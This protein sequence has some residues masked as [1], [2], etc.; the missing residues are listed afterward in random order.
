MIFVIIIESKVA[1]ISLKKGCS[2]HFK[3]AERVNGVMVDKSKYWTRPCFKGYEKVVLGDSSV[4]GFARIRKELAGV[5]I[6]AYG[7]IEI[8]EMVCILQ[9]G[10][11][12]NDWDLT[13]THIRNRF[14]ANRDE[15]PTIRFCKHCYSECANEFKGE[16]IFVI[17]LNN[18]LKAEK[19]PFAMPNGQNMQNYT[20]MFEMLDQ[21]CNKMIPNAEIRFAPVLKVERLAE[22]NS[23]LIE[24]AATKIAEGIAARNMIEMDPLEP[25]QKKLFD[26]DGVHMRNREGTDFWMKVF[27]NKMKNQ[28]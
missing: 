20:G 9:A 24:L 17:G 11:L 16:V 2:W 27:Q 22:E 4:R 3:R 8:L 19:T 21:A 13:K 5:S 26:D 7:G 1:I 6:S 10:K 14:Q 15:F 18:I 28:K 23:T 12:L 25:L